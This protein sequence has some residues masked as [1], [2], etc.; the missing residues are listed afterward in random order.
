[1]L[2]LF[3]RGDRHRLLRY[4]FAMLGLALFAGLGLANAA[5][6]Q[7]QG[8]LIPW[9]LIDTELG[10]LAVM[11]GFKP[12]RTFENIA[13]GRNGAS[14]V[15]ISGDQRTPLGSFEIAWIS[16]SARYTQFFGLNYPNLDVA[17]RALDENRISTNT[18]DKI[19]IALD[20]GRLPPQDTPLGGNLGI[21]GLG[22]SD[23]DIH[24]S[25]N[26]TNGCVALTDGQLKELARYVTIGTPVIIR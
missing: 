14:E 4:I 22:K 10:R 18:F 19:K 26:W 7:Q 8:R 15:R 5:V 20:A 9:I 12:I 13:I 23:P 16:D 17:K 3:K 21:H 6:A 24:A 11:K 1:M 25:F 2:S